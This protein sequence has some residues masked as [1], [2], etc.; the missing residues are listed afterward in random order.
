LAG[1]AIDAS[2]GPAFAAGESAGIE[3]C[4]APA[5][6]RFAFT[7]SGFVFASSSLPTVCRKRENERPFTV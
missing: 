6:L 7:L 4:F 2:G 5:A 1:W 3:G